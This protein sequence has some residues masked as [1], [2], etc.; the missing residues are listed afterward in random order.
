MAT[1]P[2]LKL[3]YV[4]VLLGKSYAPGGSDKPWLNKVVITALVYQLPFLFPLESNP[5]GFNEFLRHVFTSM[6][7]TNQCLVLG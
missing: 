3:W 5:L 4:A 7:V 6:D 1:S 2:E